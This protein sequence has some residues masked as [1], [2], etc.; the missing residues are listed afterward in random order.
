MRLPH[1][2]NW[3][4]I[5]SWL[6]IDPLSNDRLSRI[7]TV[8]RPAPI[9]TTNQFQAAPEPSLRYPGAGNLLTSACRQAEYTLVDAGASLYYVPFVGCINQ[10]PDCCPF[11]PGPTAGSIY[12][13][14]LNQKHDLLDRCPSDYYSVSAGGCC[15]RLVMGI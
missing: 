5:C 2:R 12:P 1:R 3:E 4:V 8:T 9:T 7:S 13:H 14:P 15:P 6:N 10:K 11:A